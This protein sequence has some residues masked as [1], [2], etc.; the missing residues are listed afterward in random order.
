MKEN[1]KIS[2]EIL[3]IKINIEDQFSHEA[4]I[5]EEYNSC[6]LC[7]SGLEFTH[8]T[9]FIKNEVEEI[10]HCGLCDLQNK[11]EMHLLQ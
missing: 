3:N 6:A 4:Q 10:A 7:G 5:I 8:N 2:Q 9:H 11:K 1:S